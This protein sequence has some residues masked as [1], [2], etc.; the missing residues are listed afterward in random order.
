MIEDAGRVNGETATQKTTYIEFVQDIQ[1]SK[2]H[3]ML[4]E[5]KRLNGRKIVYAGSCTLF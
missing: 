4:R 2:Y 1:K 3:V 5:S